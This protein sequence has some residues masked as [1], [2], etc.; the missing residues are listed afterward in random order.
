MATNTTNIPGCIIVPV[1]SQ[2]VEVTDSVWTTVAAIIGI[3]IGVAFGVIISYALYRSFNQPKRN[4]AVVMEEGAITMK[5]FSKKSSSNIEKK[6]LLDES[7]NADMRDSAQNSVVESSTALPSPKK[8]HDISQSLTAVFTQSTSQQIENELQEQDLRYLTHLETA[9]HKEKQETFILLLKAVLVTLQEQ[10]HIADNDVKHVITDYEQFISDENENI[11]NQKQIKEKEI[12]GRFGTK[13]T[14]E[15]EEELEEIYKQQNKKTAKIIQ[16]C[17]AKASEDIRIIATDLSEEQINEVMG[18][19]I[20]NMT[21]VDK[22]YQEELNRQNQILVDRL[23]K[24]KNALQKINQL[25]EEELEIVTV[26]VSKHKDIFNKLK[27]DKKLTDENIAKIEKNFAEQLE[28]VQKRLTEERDREQEMLVQKL[29]KRR[30]KKMRHLNIQHGEEKAEFDRKIRAVSSGAVPITGFIAEY[31]ELLTDQRRQSHD[32]STQ[33]D[34]NETREFH[35]LKQRMNLKLQDLIAEKD[36]EFFSGLRE[37]AKLSDKEAS[38]LMKTYEENV[39][40][41][42]AKLEDE[43]S[44]QQAKLKER[45]K[46]KKKKQA[47]KEKDEKLEQQELIEEQ[48]KAF[49]EVLNSQADLSEDTKNQLLMEHKQKVNELNNQLRITKMRQHKRLEQR[50]AKRQ[51]KIT[52]LR[53]DQ[54]KERA[55]MSNLSDEE[56][57]QLL[58]QQASL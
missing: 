43:R 28:N 15:K 47:E 38:K 22:K 37:L 40:E 30:K 23:N 36:S 54:A 48:E 49:N 50:L 33:L 51:G 39:N 8:D 9:M 32:I 46:E 34:E 55:N 1:L 2:T 53:K 13:M 57:R 19:I 6:P 11:T 58:E 18:Q 24:R 31:Q 41:L 20:T 10:G 12:E 42:R 35:D 21:V 16:N 17:K 56:R 27:A 14:D 26:P 45:L 4:S 3:A 25:E 44:R 29:N 52:D 7:Y 5:S